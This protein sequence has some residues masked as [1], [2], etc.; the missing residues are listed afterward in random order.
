MKANVRA[1]PFAMPVVLLLCCVALPARAA[2]PPDF[3]EMKA[4]AEEGDPDAQ[5]AMGEF[6][7]SGEERAPD[8][9]EAAKWYGKAAGQGLPEAEYAMGGMYD[10]GMGVPQDYN[11]AAHWY[12]LAADQG[13]TGAAYNL[14]DLYR[15]GV[16]VK[17][18]DSSAAKLYH[19]AAEQGSTA[20]QRSLGEMYAEG[21][22]V[23]QDYAQADTWTRLADKGAD[24]A[25][26]KTQ[27]GAPQPAPQTQS[28]QDLP[29]TPEQQPAAAPPGA[30]KDE[31]LD[32][33]EQHL[34][35]DQ[36]QQSQ[37]NVEDFKPQPANDE[38][39]FAP[40]EASTATDPTALQA[41]AEQGDPAAE[42]ALGNLF[43]VGRGVPVDYDRAYFWY[44]RAADRGYAP[45]MLCVAW[46]YEHGRVVFR[47]NNEA[48]MWYR[49]AWAH[50]YRRAWRELARWEGRTSRGYHAFHTFREGSHV[51]TVAPAAPRAARHDTCATDAR[52]LDRTRKVKAMMEAAAARDASYSRAPEKPAA[53][54]VALASNP[55]P[56]APMGGS[57]AS[58]PGV[59]NA[60]TG[61]GGHS[62]TTPNT[63]HSP[64]APN[65]HGNN[66]NANRH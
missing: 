57:H 43:N 9:A 63:G 59:S 12:Q 33:I 13:H 49:A 7:S 36:V 53:K 5:M 38:P 25:A 16:G 15:D 64:N 28:A 19:Q 24:K 45:A 44:R 3:Q 31:A 34:T 56:L 37:K 21:K 51:V 6:Y 41:E 10:S 55:Q 58:P 2:E 62:G 60:P 18:D 66:K 54:P 40:D 23:P 47:D 32:D 8:Y 61:H 4:A 11:K 35:P 22:G 14:A 42:Y 48:H 52:C 65:Q 29:F 20:A 1:L 26:A 30:P 27:P 39:P 46:Y 17:Q 50:H